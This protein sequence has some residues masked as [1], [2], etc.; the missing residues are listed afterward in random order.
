MA[1]WLLLG[2]TLLLA[3]FA[4]DAA[5]QSVDWHEPPLRTLYASPAGSGDGSSPAAPGALDRLLAML[6]PGDRVVLLPGDYPDTRISVQ[7]TAERPIRIEAAQPAVATDGHAATG[8]G[9]A[10]FRN[11]G[12]E[13]DRSA[14][15][16]VDGL[17]FTVEPD[18]YGNGI[19]VTDSHHLAFGRNLF[20][21]QSNYGL[22]LA[23][24]Q[25]SPVTQVLVEGNLFRNHLLESE[26][27]GIG[28]VRMDYG[29]RVHGTHGLVVRDNRFDG[30]FNHSA[31]LKEF[32]QDVTIRGNRFRTCGLVCIEAGQEPDTEAAGRVMDRTVS[33]VAITGNDFTGSD[34][35][36]VAVFA[37]NAGQVVIADNRFAG[38]SEPLRVANN[39]RNSRSCERQLHF[40][41]RKLRTC[42][43]GSRLTLAGRPATGVRFERNEIAGDAQL[44]LAGR[45]YADDAVTIGAAR[46]T[47]TVRICRRPFIHNGAD[48]NA[49]T[50]GLPN[51]SAAPRLHW[52]EQ[53]DFTVQDGGC[54]G[55][56]LTHDCEAE[57]NC[58]GLND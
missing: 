54:T 57:G 24:T 37:R 15:L 25:E 33:D 40:L 36:T 23:G 8:T 51:W 7:G 13:I 41:G 29:L 19:T 32:V 5:R 9:R 47:G 35:G 43:P 14:F 1:S 30:Y 12:L 6:G 21:Q 31:S 11:S 28:G 34:D 52:D 16:R 2:L 49:W 4:A 17:V 48:F 55:K 20:H 26:G 42:E 38:I 44:I 3:G 22:L 46:T 45:G 56:D 53:G 10:M 58:T 27:G 50:D 39:D 18:R